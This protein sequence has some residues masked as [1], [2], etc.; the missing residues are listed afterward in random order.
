MSINL[1][2]L[3]YFLQSAPKSTALGAPL[4]G[5]VV[6][7]E[8]YCE[9][10]LAITSENLLSTLA[11]RRPN[12]DFAWEP[13]LLTS[14]ALPVQLSPAV[15]T[16]WFW[17]TLAGHGHASFQSY[18]WKFCREIQR[19]EG[20]D[21]PLNSTVFPP[22]LGFPLSCGGSLF[23]GSGDEEAYDLIVATRVRRC[24]RFLQL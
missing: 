20:P 10:S 3:W 19:S 14:G 12:N 9:G 8:S 17:L 21:Q 11:A 15:S 24:W 4:F 22:I 18:L 1:S 5:Q 7:V 16:V 23:L 13:C 2:F 6:F